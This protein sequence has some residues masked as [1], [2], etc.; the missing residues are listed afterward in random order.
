LSGG[1]ASEGA[2]KDLVVA[3]AVMGLLSGCGGASGSPRTPTPGSPRLTVMT[4]NVNFGLAGEPATLA[5]IRAGRA[6]VVFLQE[7]N[8]GWEDALRAELAGA[9]PHMAFRHCCRAGG[10][11]VLSR[12]PIL[13][14]EL[15]PSPSGWFP[16][17][18]VIVR[19]PLGPVQAVNVH[20]H[21]AVSDSGSWISGAYTTPRLRLA[22]IARTYHHVDRSLPTLVVGDFNE[23]AAGHSVA[24]L[25][26]QGLTT[27]LPEQSTS[28]STWRYPTPLGTLRL[29]LDHIFHNGMLRLIDIRVLPAGR[30]D[31]LPVV[32][33]FERHDATS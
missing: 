32:A 5:A 25:E 4:Y 6:D 29:Q 15:V 19:T 21:P 8:E 30:S 10:L 16:S 1:G 28:Q 18:R 31:H 27:A 20:L 14:R 2:V 17:W 3:A 11:A 13:E 12:S 26:A 9:Y 23:G 24:F 22:E 7:T 33:V